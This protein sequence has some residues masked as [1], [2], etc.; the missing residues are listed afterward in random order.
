VK[1]SME[2]SALEIKSGEVKALS[3]LA[4]EKIKGA[5]IN[6]TFIPGSRI[7]ERKLAEE[8]GI[9][10]SPIKQALARLSY[11]GLAEIKPRKG[12][13]VSA[14]CRPNSAEIVMIKAGL[15]GI[16]ANFAAGNITEEG[17]RELR[18]VI[19]Q[20][21]KLNMQGDYDGLIIL[22]RVFHRNIHA[23]SQSPYLSKL[24][25]MIEP[26]YDQGEDLKVDGRKARIIVTEHQGIFEALANHRRELAEE[27]MKVHILT[28]RSETDGTVE[29]TEVKEEE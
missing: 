27:R 17:I 12:T 13:Y 7:S 18:K 2:S 14:A 1:V 24:L 26:F 11:E 23:F 6:G 15:E 20:M 28:N 9:S 21:N 10:T 16:A 8:M 29:K 25:D 4:Y 19:L 3:D 22:N 5:I